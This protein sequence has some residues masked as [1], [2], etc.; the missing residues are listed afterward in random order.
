MYK[1]LF[2]T[3]IIVT[4]G[5]ILFFSVRVIPPEHNPYDP[6]DI[7]D[8]IGLATEAKLNRYQDHSDACFSF[9]DLSGIEYS[10]LEDSIKEGP[11]GYHDALVLERSAFPYNAGLR[12]T[13]PLTAGL[14]IWERQSLVPR[15]EAYFDEVPVKVLSYGSYSCRRLYGRTAGKYSEHATGNAIDIQGFEFRDGRRITLAADWGKKTPEGRFLKALRDDACRVFGS[16]LGPDYNDAHAD[17]FHFDMGP[18][19]ICK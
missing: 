8:P 4:L 9:L 19:D 15:A 16:V 13:C 3:S 7:D 17:H 2:L 1:W 12:M 5:G 18:D 14:V 6:L 11:C 10:H